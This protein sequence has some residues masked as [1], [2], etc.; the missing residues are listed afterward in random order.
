MKKAKFS[1]CNTPML[2]LHEYNLSQKSLYKLY[3]LRKKIISNTQYI[4][5]RLSNDKVELI[6]KVIL[7]KPQGIELLEIIKDN[8]ILL[9]KINKNLNCNIED[10][11]DLLKLYK[12]INRLEKIFN[13]KKDSLLNINQIKN[14]TYLHWKR[15]FDN[16]KEKL[17]QCKW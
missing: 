5:E 16:L 15:F 2:V 11:F 14:R 9:K 8:S 13:F 6:E 7:T 17:L 3:T 10:N 12:N 1:Y 4:V